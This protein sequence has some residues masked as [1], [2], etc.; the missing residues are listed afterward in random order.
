MYT[1]TNKR[2]LSHTPQFANNAASRTITHEAFED[3]SRFGLLM[4]KSKSKKMLCF[5]VLIFLNSQSPP[6]YAC[7][8]TT[9]LLC[10]WVLLVPECKKSHTFDH[11][12]V[13]AHTSQDCGLR[14]LTV[15]RRTCS[16]VC[17][18][19]TSIKTSWRRSL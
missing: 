16:V 15:H 18:V 12:S 2:F 13:N 6:R 19:A 7:R 17:H 5:S 10:F 8:D 9:S 11:F 3:P 4:G 14:R 1:Y